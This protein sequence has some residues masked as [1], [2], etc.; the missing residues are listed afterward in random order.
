VPWCHANFTG[1]A[2]ACSISMITLV[3]ATTAVIVSATAP[4]R[5]IKDCII[6]GREMRCVIMNGPDGAVVVPY[7]GTKPRTGDLG[8]GLVAR[9]R[10]AR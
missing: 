8:Q 6:D 5:L 10:T 9:G 4:E 2:L 3:I 1:M 7:G